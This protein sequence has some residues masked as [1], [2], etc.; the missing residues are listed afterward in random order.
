MTFA[1]CPLSVY[2]SAI[3]RAEYIQRRFDGALSDNSLMHLGLQDNMHDQNPKNHS[4]GDWNRI[5]PVCF[6]PMGAHTNE[7]LSWTV[8]FTRPELWH[9]ARAKARRLLWAL[10]RRRRSECLQRGCDSIETVMGEEYHR[11]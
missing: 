6:P 7:T 1:L 4:A 9:S 3:I 11:E 2:H 5:F 8:A 10:L